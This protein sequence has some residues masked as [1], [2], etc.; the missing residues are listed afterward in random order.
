MIKYNLSLLL[1]T[2]FFSL[3]FVIIEQI[4]SIS[5]ESPNVKIFPECGGLTDHR[6]Y[7]TVNGFNP[8]GNVH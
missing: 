8:N 4:H 7:F 3:F 1:F 2:Y 6:V 5:A